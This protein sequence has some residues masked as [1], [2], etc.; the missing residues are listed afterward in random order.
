M[1]VSRFRT[2]SLKMRNLTN[3]DLVAQKWLQTSPSLPRSVLLFGSAGTVGRTSTQSGH[4]W[5]GPCPFPPHP[6]GSA[7]TA[8]SSHPLSDL[9]L[10]HQNFPFSAL[11]LPSIAKQLQGTAAVETGYETFSWITPQMWC[12][13]VDTISRFV[14]QGDG[15]NRDVG[16]KPGAGVTLWSSE[17]EGGETWSSFEE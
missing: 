16:K 13:N 5:H 17:G 15:E 10:E 2:C 14:S 3:F 12:A 6:L 11:P 1:Y 8:S 9:D 4:G 7:S